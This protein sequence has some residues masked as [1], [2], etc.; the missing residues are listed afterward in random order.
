MNDPKTRKEISI[1]LKKLIEEKGMTQ[2]Q[3]A[4]KAKINTNYYAQIERGVVN[5]S[6]KVILPI[7]KTLGVKSSEILPF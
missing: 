3:V 6:I 2:E 7:A 4:T 1:R 5:T